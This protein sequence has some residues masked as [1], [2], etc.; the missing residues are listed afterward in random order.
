MEVLYC[1]GGTCDP[2]PSCYIAT[3]AFGT[4]F[5][6]K[7]DVLRLFRD[8]YLMSSAAGKVFVIAYYK[9]S[10]PIAGYIVERDWL[11]AVV[12]I[13]LLPVLGFVSLFV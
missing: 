1:P 11:K 12:R 2:C 5:E 7:A 8:D 9:Y 13:L 4:H 6:A 3:V 10:P